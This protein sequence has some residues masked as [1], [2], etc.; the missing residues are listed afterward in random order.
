VGRT[1][2]LMPFH[3]KRKHFRKK[4]IITISIQHHNGSSNNRLLNISLGGAFLQ[5][6]NNLSVG[7]EITMGIQYLGLRQPFDI[8]GIIAHE[9]P[10]VGV[11]IRFENVYQYHKDKINYLWR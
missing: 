1:F 11:G 6:N 7:Q 8:D 9:I 2:S 10:G 3:D 4:C 5:T